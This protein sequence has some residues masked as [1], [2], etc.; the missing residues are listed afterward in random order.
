MQTVLEALIKADIS[1]LE[2][3]FFFEDS[4]DFWEFGNDDNRTIAEVRK[5]MSD[6]FRRFVEKLKNTEVALPEE[7]RT[8]IL[9]AHKQAGEPSWHPKTA[10]D[11]VSADELLEKEDLSDIVHYA[12]DFTPWAEALGFLIADNKYTQDNLIGVLTHFL[13]E[14]SFFG[15]EET[16]KKEKREEVFASVKEAKEHPERLIKWDPEKMR[17]ELGL[18]QEE[19]YPL[20]KDYLSQIL[21]NINEYNKYCSVKE[22][23]KIKDAIHKVNDCAID[24]LG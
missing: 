13:S 19:E 9:Y 5:S 10:V 14:L 20:E 4:P 23:E 16:E 17:E 8:M 1:N 11:L 3:S 6:N 22:L 12:F 15:Y 24:D 18:P 2:G 21:Q 7:G